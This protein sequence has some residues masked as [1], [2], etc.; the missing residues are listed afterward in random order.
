MR[1]KVCQ[2]CESHDRI[3]K[4]RR[5]DLYLCWKCRNQKPAYTTIAE[6]REAFNRREFRMAMGASLSFDE[7]YEDFSNDCKSFT[8]IIQSHGL[9]RGR[10]GR[11]YNKYFSQI[12]PR[13]P[14][15]RTRQKVCTR[16]RR[17]IRAKVGFESKFKSLISEATR[18]GV[19]ATLHKNSGQVVKASTR[20][21]NLNGLLCLRLNSR[22]VSR[23][24]YRD[25]WRF[26]FR[27]PE[28]VTFVIL[29]ISKKGRK[30]RFLVVP[31]S[32]MSG[33]EIIYVPARGYSGYNGIRP[34]VDWLAYEDRWDLLGGL[35][36]STPAPQ[37]R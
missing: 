10:I 5:G 20:F 23:I 6:A 18:H 35:V 37:V 7:L 16:K 12:I 31:S 2:K 4:Q 14:D 34:K 32:L 26:S 15:A 36:A 22:I 24:G 11:L 29:Q 33:S 25:Y 9:S 30:C 28:R 1:L 3:R 19:K 8:C 17:A 27:H 21:V 13:R